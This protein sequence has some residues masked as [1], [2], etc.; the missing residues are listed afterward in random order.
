MIISSQATLQHRQKYLDKSPFKSMNIFEQIALVYH[1][2]SYLAHFFF[3]S[4]FVTIYSSIWGSGL[5]C[6]NINTHSKH[7]A[8][9]GR[10]NIRQ[11]FNSSYCSGN[12]V[13]Y[14]YISTGYFYASPLHIVAVIRVHQDRVQHSGIEKPPYH[15]V[16]RKITVYT[17]AT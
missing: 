4:Y 13:H 9:K 7:H 11:Q 14:N 8:Q 16:W 5:K 12:V 15:P 10:K 17:G 3:S 2:C 1:N 6:G